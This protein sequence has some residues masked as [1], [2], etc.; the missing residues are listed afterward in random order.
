M[1]LTPLSDEGVDFSNSTQ[2]FDFLHEVEDDSV[3]QLVANEYAAY[4]WYGIA[5]VIG[6]ATVFNLSRRFLLWMR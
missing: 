1:A 3:L 4:F 6:V 2:A 5:V